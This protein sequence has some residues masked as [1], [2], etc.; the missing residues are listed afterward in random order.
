[1]RSYSCLRQRCRGRPRGR[2]PGRNPREARPDR[3]AGRHARCG[4]VR[5]RP[6]CEVDRTGPGNLSWHCRSGLCAVRCEG[7][8]TMQVEQRQERI[9]GRRQKRKLA[10]AARVRRQVLRYVLL[11]LLL[12][13]SA[14]MLTQVP[15]RVSNLERDIVIRGNNVASVEQVRDVLANTVGKP[16]YK[17]DP[18]RLEAQVRSLEAVRYAFVRRYL[19][20]HPHLVVDVVEE[21]PWATLGTDEGHPPL[22]L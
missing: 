21:F 2:R 14:A 6:A 15:W 17:L 22:M 8:M 3:I 20:P 9:R 10:R 13:G 19:F 12:A 5:G 7:A 16:I 11:C 18:R 4:V 1:M